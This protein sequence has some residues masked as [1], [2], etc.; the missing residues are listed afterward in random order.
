MPIIKKKLLY[1]DGIVNN[2]FTVGQKLQKTT[3]T[4]QQD[5]LLIDKS[6]VVSGTVSGNTAQKDEDFVTL[7]QSRQQLQNKR[8]KIVYPSA[9]EPP[10]VY[11]AEAAGDTYSE[12][13]DSVLENAIVKRNNLGTFLVPEPLDAWSELSV[14]PRKYVD[15]KFNT[16][17]TEIEKQ[18]SPFVDINVTPEQFTTA[19]DGQNMY[20]VQR[21]AYGYIKA[22]VANVAKLNADSSYTNVEF[23]VNIL[24]NG[25]IQVLIQSAPITGIIRLIEGG[26][27]PNYVAFAAQFTDIK[28]QL[29]A[30]QQR[31]TALESGVDSI[32][33]AVTVTASSWTLAGGVYSVS[34]PKT[35]H[36]VTNPVVSAVLIIN[37][38]N[39]YVNTLYSF[40]VDT[41]QNITVSLDIAANAKIVIRRS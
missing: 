32:V 14:T 15:D 19:P 35:Q 12:M 7:A 2:K 24:Q 13:S 36:N 41:E 25:D 9:T 31:L 29:I 11:T 3:I 5:S 18:L 21:S 30:V 23:N 37:A 22:F 8:D 20:T 17:I 26:L 33:Y 1:C 6:V 28:A 4:S 10:R 40:A 16:I 39:T 34:I 27:D 38:D